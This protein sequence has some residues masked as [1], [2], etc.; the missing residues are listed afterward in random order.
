MEIFHIFKN[1]EGTKYMSLLKYV[2]SGLI[3]IYR[4]GFAAKCLKLLEND[5]TFKPRHMPK[6]LLNKK[7]PTS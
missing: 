6:S 7:T 3:W 4:K 5:A 2:Q 1:P